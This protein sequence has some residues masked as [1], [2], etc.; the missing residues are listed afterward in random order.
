MLFCEYRDFKIC[1]AA[2][3]SNDLATVSPLR[4]MLNY[5]WKVLRSLWSPDFNEHFEKLRFREV[6]KPFLVPHDW[7]TIAQTDRLGQSILENHGDGV[8]H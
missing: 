8:S 7:L 3:M 1:E 5:C 6:R 2:V 4:N